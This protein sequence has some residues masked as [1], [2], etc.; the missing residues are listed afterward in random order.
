AVAPILVHMVRAFGP[1]DAAT[2]A[3]A[4]RLL[5]E[6]RIPHHAVI[7][8]WFDWVAV[9]QI[10]WFVLALA[11]LRGTRLYWALGLPAALSAMLTLVQL[12]TGNPT[13]AL[14]FP[15]RVSAVLVPI[16]T[17]VIFAR[18]ATTLWRFRP[19]VWISFILALAAGGVWVLATGRGY[20]TNDDE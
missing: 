19:W 15:W 16:A 9:A 17:T 5:V 13:L 20:H 6:R 7:G 14:A 2:F 3:E 12:A 8:R 11:M 18:V 1:T 4:Q 10:A